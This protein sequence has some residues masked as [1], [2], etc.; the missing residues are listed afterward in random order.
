[1]GKPLDTDKFNEQLET[2]EVF[3]P[4]AK[5]EKIKF[6]KFTPLIVALITLINLTYTAITGNSIFG[7]SNDELAIYVNLILTVVATAVAGYK[8]LPIS[9]RARMRKNVADQV[10]PK[11]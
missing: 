7:I 4:S 3:V 8:D 10:I 5:E 11:K 2:V 1:M 6:T 9:K